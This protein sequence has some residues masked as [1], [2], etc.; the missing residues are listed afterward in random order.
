MILA[1][2]GREGL[3]LQKANTVFIA[4][5]YVHGQVPNAVAAVVAVIV[6]L[7]LDAGC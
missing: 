2:C 6:Q 7:L 5:R 1:C 4:A 3:I